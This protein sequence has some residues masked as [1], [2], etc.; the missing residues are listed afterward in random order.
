MFPFVKKAYYWLIDSD[1]NKDFL[2]DNEG[3][4]HTFDLWECFGASS[5]TSSLF[6]AASLAYIK[7]SEIMEDKDAQKV[8]KEYFQKGKVN[9]EKKLWQKTYFIEYNNRHS[10]NY[11]G[12][13]KMGLSCTVGQLVGQWYA[14]LLDLGYIVSKDKVQKA[15]KT[16]FALNAKDT[17]YGLTN[18]V[19][20][21]GSRNEA[22]SHATNVWIGLT[23]AF[24]SLAIYEGFEEEAEAVG[25][26]LWATLCD[27]E[28]NIWNQP[29]MISSADGHYLF[30][31]RYMR[32][33]SVWA[34]VFSLAKRN[35]KIEHFI[36]SLKKDLSK[37]L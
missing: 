12:L 5:Y 15:I 11:K 13:P 6:L 22:C 28:K 8:A 2:P 31:D 37:A 18:A 4:D 7:L 21:D 17:P 26:R 20:A 32:N 19:F 25:A 3:A 35:K 36:G 16:V 34:I 23:F 24:L 33:L 9:F 14:H 30:G 27:K 29:D 1:K 10:R